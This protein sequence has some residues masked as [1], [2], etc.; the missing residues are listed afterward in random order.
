M[1]SRVKQPQG[2]ISVLLDRT[3][4]LDERDDAAM[5]LSAYDEALPV[6]IEAAQNT[7]EDEMVAA[8]IGESIGE[9]WTRLGGF[10]PDAVARMHPAARN[11]IGNWFDLG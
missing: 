4:R 11:E 5:D 9:M 2:L 1:F 3:A 8:S 6:L 10:D 7:A